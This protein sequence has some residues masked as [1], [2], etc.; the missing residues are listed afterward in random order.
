MIKKLSIQGVRSFSPADNKGQWI[1]FGSPLTL[2]L[3]VNG[4]GKTTIIETLK[5]A[6]TSQFPPNSAKGSSFVNDPKLS[7]NETVS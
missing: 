1:E 6:I 7:F 5:Y 3:G 4:S 2:I